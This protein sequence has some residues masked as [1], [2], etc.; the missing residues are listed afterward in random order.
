LKPLLIS[1]LFSLLPIVINAQNDDIFLLKNSNIIDPHYTSVRIVKFGIANDSSKLAK[2]N[3]VMFLFSLP[4][5]CYQKVI[6]QQ[7]F[8]SCLYAPSCSEFS[9]MLFKKYGLVGGFLTSADRL[10]RCDRISATSIRPISIDET[11]GKIHESVNI[12]LMK[13]LF[14]P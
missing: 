7:I 12:Y 9:R 1:V 13:Q 4:M 14:K 10:M 6:S 3:P 8:A 2:A 5:Y 11:D